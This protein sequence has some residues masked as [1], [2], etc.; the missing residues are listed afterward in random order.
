M[1]G[2]VKIVIHILNRVP[3]KLVS[4]M[5]YEL[6]TGYK[7][8]LNYIRAWGCPA[9]TMI[10]NSNVDKLKPKT[11]SYHFLSYPEKSKSFLFLL[12]RRA[13]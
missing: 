3:S 4:K 10:F 7:P 12:S 2:D 11:V 9:E 8:S 5:S 13:Y 6:W 1:D